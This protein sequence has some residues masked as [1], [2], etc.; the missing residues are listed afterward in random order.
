MIPKLTD[1]LVEGRILL[2]LLG[3]EKD[4]VLKELSEFAYQKGQIEDPEPMY[5]GL[6]ARENL[7]STGIGE[8]IA[9]PHTRCSGAKGLFLIFARSEIGVDFDSLDGEPAHLLVT[10][11]GPE[12]NAKD[13]LRVLSRTA[14][15]LK[16]TDFR[17]RILAASSEEEALDFVRKEEIW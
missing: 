6:L 7:I 9:I 15:L 8:G 13:Q 1:Y 14:R 10:I 3:T 12:E 16:Q 5:R 11:V 17:D 4:E 2:D